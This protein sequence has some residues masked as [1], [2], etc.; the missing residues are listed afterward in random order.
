L[1]KFILGII[2]VLVAIPTL[3]ALTSFI[4]SFMEMIKSWFAIV[5]A[6]NNQKIQ[7]LS[8]PD[9]PQRAIGFAIE[10]GVDEDDL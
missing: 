3:D 8:A 7:D 6:K 5:I 2:F 1:E 4:V 10:E 9:I